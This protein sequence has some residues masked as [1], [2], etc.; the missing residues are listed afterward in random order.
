[1]S[2]TAEQA[3]EKARRLAMERGIAI[4]SADLY[5]SIAYALEDVGRFVADSPEYQ[6]QQKDYTV[7][8]ASGVASLSAVTDML[9][10]TIE[11]VKHPD[12]DG[13]GTDQYLCRLPNGT[14]QDLAIWY[15][16]MNPPYIIEA[17]AIKA[18]LGN[19]TWPAS[20]DLP[21]NANLTVRANF[22]PIIS[23][24]HPRFEEKLI[25]FMLIR[26]KQAA[27]V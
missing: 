14:E 10:D 5:E 21:P 11:V 27:A 25:E 1:M 23:T 2:I 4:D 26:A 15:D 19:A 13:A 7:A 20:D 3:V 17:N 6:L 22:T 8:I 16:P 12:I 9:I 24:I 18:S